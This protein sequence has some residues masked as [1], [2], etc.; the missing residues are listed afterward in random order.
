MRNTRKLKIRVQIPQLSIRNGLIPETH[1][2]YPS[3]SELP[4]RVP[5]NALRVTISGNTINGWL[6]HGLTEALIHAG[7]S[8][9]HSFDV[10]NTSRL[11]EKI[12][13]LKYGYHRKAF[14]NG[15][16]E[17]GAS[18]PECEVVIGKK[19]LVAEMFGTFAGA[20]KVFAEMPMKLTPIKKDLE[21]GVRGVC[22]FGNFLEIASSPRS[23]VNG[24]PFNTYKQYVV[25]NVDAI[26]TLK[27]YEPNLR[28]EEHLAALLH[29]VEYLNEH[30]DEYN[31]QIGGFRT[32]GNGFATVTAIPLAFTEKES[33]DYLIKLIAL[34]DK[35][36][37]ADGITEDMRVKIE[38]WKAEKERYAKI[39]AEELKVQKEQFG[40]D[41]K[42]WKME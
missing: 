25:A 13:D 5:G 3:T 8:P 16:K 42:W 12:E 7:V 18:K 11:T 37:D 9:C 28:M 29:A 36:D 33:V 19:C 24:I 26:L 15:K 2:N 17:N 23:M 38:D 10:D 40:L 4:I 14:K 6:R 21:K 31:H 1:S 27:F 20:H 34:E 41:K 22:G 32:T 35:A 30:G 39:F